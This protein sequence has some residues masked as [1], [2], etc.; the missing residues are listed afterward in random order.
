MSHLLRDPENMRIFRQEVDRI[1]KTNSE[2]GQ[3]AAHWLSQMLK[4]DKVGEPGVIKLFEDMKVLS[5]LSENTRPSSVNASTGGVKAFV[6]TLSGAQKKLLV[7]ETSNDDRNIVRRTLRPLERR[8]MS[9][10]TMVFGSLAAGLG[11][12][13]KY[14]YDNSIAKV[15]K[16]SGDIP[17]QQSGDDKGD[18]DF[19]DQPNPIASGPTKAQLKLVAEAQKEQYWAGG[20]AA[21][22]VAASIPAVISAT[23]LA[24][25]VDKTR[26]R[27]EVGT[28]MAN[29]DHVVNAVKNEISSQS[30]AAAAGGR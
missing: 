14:S 5:S 12:S 15:N 20:Y 30:T 13:A 9:R 16:A 7:T 10:R 25:G 27:G 23:Q 18:L 8:D 29:M 2:P 3:K 1:A 22:A 11:L 6:D 28:L 26:F 21:G 17:R 19:F 24:F 4:S